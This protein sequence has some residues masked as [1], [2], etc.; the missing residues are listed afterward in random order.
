[1]FFNI[2]LTTKNVD[3]KARK[4]PFFLLKRLNLLKIE[5][6]TA[7]RLN[8]RVDL[9]GIPSIVSFNNRRF[10]I[11]RKNVKNSKKVHFI[12]KGSKKNIF[13]P[14]KMKTCFQP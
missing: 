2:I 1:M 3:K 6:A 5:I 12:K 8:L 4:R 10:D 13:W 9:I 7:L 11:Q 14:N